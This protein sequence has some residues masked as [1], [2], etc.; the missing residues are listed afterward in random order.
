MMMINYAGD[1]SISLP[2]ALTTRDLFWFHSD[3]AMWTVHKSKSVMPR[4]SISRFCMNLV[5]LPA[6]YLDTPIPRT[7]FNLIFLNHQ[8]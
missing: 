6:L 3:T 5:P 2:P 4:G 8:P 1:P 7:L